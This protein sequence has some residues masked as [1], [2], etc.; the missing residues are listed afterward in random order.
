MLMADIALN[1]DHISVHQ[2][3]Q[4]YFNRNFMKILAS[5]YIQVEV[6]TNGTLLDFGI[7]FMTKGKTSQELRKVLYTSSW[8]VKFK[9]LS[10][11]GFMFDNG[12]HMVQ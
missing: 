4:L 7:K 11:E 12:G 3:K 5:R 9:C 6:K 10:E 1:K 2:S 8:K